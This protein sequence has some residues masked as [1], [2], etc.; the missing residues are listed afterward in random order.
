VSEWRRSGHSVQQFA[1]QHGLDPQR[2]YFWRKQSKPGPKRKSN[3]RSR[4]ELVEVQLAGA[5]LPVERRVT[6]ELPSGRCLS[7]AEHIDVD[8]LERLVA[9]LERKP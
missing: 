3:N 1:T 5:P 7:V 4:P 6:I 2:V 9:V 8:V